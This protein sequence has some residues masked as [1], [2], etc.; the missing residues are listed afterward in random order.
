MYYVIE[1]QGRHVAGLSGLVLLPVVLRVLE[2]L[3]DVS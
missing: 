2:L 1:K 3:Y